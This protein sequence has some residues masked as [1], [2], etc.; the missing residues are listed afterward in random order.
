MTSIP[1]V[2]RTHNGMPHMA[3][4]SLRAMRIM[5]LYAGQLKR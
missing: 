4:I 1:S 5:K 3:F 2:M